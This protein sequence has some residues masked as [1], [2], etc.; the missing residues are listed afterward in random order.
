MVQRKS[1]VMEEH[2][3][4]RI[5]HY[6][7]DFFLHFRFIAVDNAFAACAFFVLKGTFVKTHKR[8]FLEL[9]AFWTYFAFSS[10]VVFAV[11]FYHVSN[12]F[13]FT[14]HS[15]MFRIRWLRLHEIPS[16]QNKL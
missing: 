1:W 13:L 10:V 12:G 2:S 5:T 4:T 9:P 11:D 8:V 15:F 7:F 6:N 14:F 3:W 16:L